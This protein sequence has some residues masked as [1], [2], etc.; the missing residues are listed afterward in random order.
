MFEIVWLRTAA[1][2]MHVKSIYG[3]YQDHDSNHLAF[4]RGT[5]Q[6]WVW[7]LIKM[8]GSHV[9]LFWERCTET[10]LLDWLIG[11]PAG[12]ELTAQAGIKMIVWWVAVT[13]SI[14]L[15]IY[16][17]VYRNPVLPWLHWF[18]SLKQSLLQHFS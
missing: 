18:F 9:R 15:Q 11:K 6:H 16:L 17:L 2:K 8:F 3:L 7:L 4:N 14:I 5:C 12:V 13:G 1:G 10:K